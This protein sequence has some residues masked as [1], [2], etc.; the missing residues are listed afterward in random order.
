MTGR[1]GAVA[2][3][4]VRGTEGCRPAPSKWFTSQESPAQAAA[5]ADEDGWRPRG[6]DRKNDGSV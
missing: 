1:L 2:A 3:G 6:A 5:A 4:R